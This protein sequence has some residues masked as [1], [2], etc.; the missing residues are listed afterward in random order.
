MSPDRDTLD[1]DALHRRLDRLL[2]AHEAGED[3]AWW[4]LA[5]LYDLQPITGID[6][7]KGKTNVVK[8]RI[9][10]WAGELVYQRGLEKSQTAA[11]EEAAEIAGL[12]NEAIWQWLN[13]VPED[14]KAELAPNE[15]SDYTKLLANVA[16]V[17]SR[18]H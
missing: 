7:L 9:K 13:A 10:Q 11:V 17:L 14:R 8:A 3:K 2:D 12:T 6:A 1:R 4:T 15:D 5:L 18:R 16:S